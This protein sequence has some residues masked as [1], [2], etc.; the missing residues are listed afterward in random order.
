MKKYIIYLIAVFSIILISCNEDNSVE[1][2]EDHFEASGMIVKQN[3]TEYMKI[4][5]A[6]FDSLYNSKFSINANEAGNIYTVEFLDEN[7]ANIGV[8][9][10]DNKSFSWIISDTS[11]A[12]ITKTDI[13]KKWEFKLTGKKPGNTSVELRMMHIDHPD[14]KTPS[15]SIEVK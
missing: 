1:S 4:Y 12:E 11:I 7:G 9:D 2:H 15:I 10:E 14:F 6:Q 13:N 8:P 3:G 5:N